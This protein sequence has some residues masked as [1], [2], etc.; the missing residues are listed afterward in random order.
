MFDIFADLVTPLS[1][2]CH[3][4][5]SW[6]LFPKLWS[7]LGTNAV[8]V[9]VHRARQAHGAAQHVLDHCQCRTCHKRPWN[10][11][12]TKVIVKYSKWVKKPAKFALERPQNQIQA[13]YI[14]TGSDKSTMSDLNLLYGKDGNPRYLDRSL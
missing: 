10:S 6:S 12:P 13:R 5:I 8:L 1:H 2:S 9:K 4:A 7:V 14:Q 3:H 11:L